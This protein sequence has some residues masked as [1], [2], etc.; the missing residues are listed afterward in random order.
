MSGGDP[1]SAAALGAR[2]HHGFYRSSA[3]RTALFYGTVLLVCLLFHVFVALG[4]SAFFLRFYRRE[5]SAFLRHPLRGA[6][7]ARSPSPLDAYGIEVLP[8]RRA[9]ARR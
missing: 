7:L 3:V 1:T 5:V 9:G 6:A 8:P 4:I 2:I